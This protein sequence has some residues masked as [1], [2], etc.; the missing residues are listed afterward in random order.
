MYIMWKM[1]EDGVIVKYVI[2]NT[3]TRSIHSSWKNHSY[4]VKTCKDLNRM[5]ASYA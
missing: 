4:A 2:V 1:Y 3:G 5:V